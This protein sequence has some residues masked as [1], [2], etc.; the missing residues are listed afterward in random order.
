MINSYTLPFT[1]L[2]AYLNA[3]LD[4]SHNYLPEKMGCILGV[5]MGGFPF[6]EKEHN[7]FKNKGHRKLVLFY[8]LCDSKYGF[9]FS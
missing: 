5:G 2:E 1:Q 3:G 9:W 4:K 6:M 7:N 8:P